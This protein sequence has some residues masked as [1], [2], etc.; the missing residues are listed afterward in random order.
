MPFDIC[1]LLND[2]QKINAHKIMLINASNYF[3]EKIGNLSNETNKRSNVSEESPSSTTILEIKHINSFECLELCIQFIYTGGSQLNL[4]NLE[5]IDEL[6]ITAK[7]LELNDL[8]GLCDL[9]NANIETKNIVLNNNSKN[10]IT[11]NKNLNGYSKSSNSFQQY[12]KINNNSCLNNN[13]LI[14]NNNNNFLDKNNS[15]LFYFLL[16]SI[17]NGALILITGN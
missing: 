2:N 16:N 6:K 17:N 4:T 13:D 3:R 15:K 11:E 7:L 14:S 5:L 1:L 10:L 12:E 9:I 8:V